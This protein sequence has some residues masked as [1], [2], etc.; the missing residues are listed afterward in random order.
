MA[1]IL[2]IDASVAVKFIID[3]PGSDQA[4]QYLPKRRGNFVENE[5]ILTA[6]IHILLEVHNTL[7]KKFRKSL[8]DFTPLNIAHSLL[9]RR[10]RLDLIDIE[11]VEKSRLI[12]LH[13][14]FNSTANA[15]P[16]EVSRSPFNIYDCIYIAHA[17]KFGTI[18]VTADRQ[19][20]RIA[21]DG[22]AIPVE[23]ISPAQPA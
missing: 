23:L 13:A 22:F 20:A 16:I 5:H 2:T 4:R 8:I 7:A 18:L 10:F 9:K 11:L 1:M 17:Q 15:F 19:L 3:E 21:K 6:P 14:D 12:S